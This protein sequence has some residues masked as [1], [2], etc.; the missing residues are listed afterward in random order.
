MYALLIKLAIYLLAAG[1]AFF[2]FRMFINMFSKAEGASEKAQQAIDDRLKETNKYNYQRLR[3]S[4]LGIM[5]RLHNYEM[6][7]SNY[8]VLRLTIGGIFAAAVFIIAGMRI[9]ALAL[10]FLVGYFGCDFY[11]KHKNKT[12][13]DEMLNDIFNIY[14]TLKIQ[15]TSKI[16]IFDALQSCLTMVKNK[17]MKEA[18]TELV[19]NLS[20]KRVSYLDSVEHFSNRFESDSIANLCAFLK[21]YMQ[22]GVSEKYI[23]DIMS[24]IN[25]IATASAMKEEHSIESK[26]NAIAFVYFVAILAVVLYCIAVTLSG[27][28]VFGL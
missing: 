13:N 1:V 28:N 6:M 12:D 21:S 3:L 23:E 8:M 11:F 14:L 18:L 17:R 9:P 27:T 25:E 20:D 5:Y 10:A 2:C 15:L 26:A 24:E 19:V 4:R 16:P 7:P 22:Y